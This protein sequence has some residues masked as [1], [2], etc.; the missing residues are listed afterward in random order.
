MQA[1]LLKEDQVICSSPIRILAR[2]ELESPMDWGEREKIDRQGISV[3]RSER[4]G[5]ETT[6]K[7]MGVA[8]A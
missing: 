3:K 2:L 4:G 5:E 1:C 6:Q 8:V 7:K